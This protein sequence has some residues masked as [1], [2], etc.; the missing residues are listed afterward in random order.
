MGLHFMVKE[1]SQVDICCLLIGIGLWLLVIDINW[2]LNCRRWRG[3]NLCAYNMQQQLSGLYH[4]LS[5]Y[6]VQMNLW[7]IQLQRN[8]GNQVRSWS[9]PPEMWQ[10][11]ILFC[12]S[13]NSTFTKCIFIF[14]LIILCHNSIL[15]KINNCSKFE[16]EFNT[17]LQSLGSILSSS[18][19]AE[20]YLA[21]LAQWILGVKHEQNGLW[22]VFSLDYLWDA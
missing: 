17:E 2:V 19:Q 22:C 18:S 10:S 20:P 12:K 11:L 5:Y 13:K 3:L 8:N 16:K 21:H 1:S 6:V 15:T 7:M 9:Q 14:R 4:L